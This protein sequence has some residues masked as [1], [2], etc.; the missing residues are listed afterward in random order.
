MNLNTV[1]LCCRYF[2]IPARKEHRGIGGLFFDDLDAAGAAFD[3]Q[4]CLGCQLAHAACTA[5]PPVAHWHQRLQHEI[6][7]VADMQCI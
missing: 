2:Y 4:V 7:D 3:V 5:T 1:P 6:Y